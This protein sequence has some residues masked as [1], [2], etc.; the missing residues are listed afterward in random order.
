MRKTK[1]L[2]KGLRVIV[3]TNGYKKDQTL[4]ELVD[5]SPDS[6][7]TDGKFRITGK[8]AKKL[9]QYLTKALKGKVK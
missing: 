9:I 8:T 2:S 1:K 5:I 6:V 4:I 7:I 3:T